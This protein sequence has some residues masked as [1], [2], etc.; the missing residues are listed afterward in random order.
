ML[1]TLVET[2]EW[3]RLRAVGTEDLLAYGRAIPTAFVP[4][5]IAPW[6]DRAGGD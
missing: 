6:P 5:R 3:A 1:D 4:G 2:L